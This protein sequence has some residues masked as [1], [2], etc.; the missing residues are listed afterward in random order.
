MNIIKNIPSRYKNV[1]YLFMLAIYLSHHSTSSSW[2]PEGKGMEENVCID[3]AYFKALQLLLK[4]V[5]VKLTFLYVVSPSL[6]TRLCPIF[7]CLGV[8]ADL[9]NE[10]PSRDSNV[11]LAVCK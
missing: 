6:S 5:G 4:K 8:V 7:F 9:G 11:P 2:N 1:S 10:A 3:F